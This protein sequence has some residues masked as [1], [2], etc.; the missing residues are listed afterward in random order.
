MPEVV[1]EVKE[2]I[3]Q[4]VKA[5]ESKAPEPKAPETKA[6]EMSAEAKR[7]SDLEAQLKERD[8]KISD[9][10]TTISTIEERQRQIE[11]AKQI[12]QS[13][14]DLEKRLQQIEEIRLTDPNGAA[15]EQAKLFKEIRSSAAQQAQGAVSQQATLEKLRS[16][17]K[18]SNPD[19]DDDVVDYVMERADV[20]ARTGKFKTA[21]EAIEAATTLVKSKFEGYAKKRNASPVIPDGAKAET[22]N[23]PPPA[24]TPK[25]AV[26]PSPAEELEARKSAQQRKI[27]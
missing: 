14:D 5:P 21:D 22:G 19:F 4:E 6:P 27:I 3:K 26:I 23:N 12:Q 10:S 25:E 11:A 18:S 13:D 16:G 1:T 9:L 17:V 7:L 2:E 20:L 8:T 15:R 24:T